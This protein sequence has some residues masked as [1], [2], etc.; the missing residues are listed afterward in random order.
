MKYLDKN[1]NDKIMGLMSVNLN[2]NFE[3]D[4]TSTNIYNN[5]DK[6]LDKNKADID[7]EIKERIDK[8]FKKV[9]EIAQ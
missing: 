4:D 5:V 8:I 2:K 1:K 3:L 7:A 9:E 6:L